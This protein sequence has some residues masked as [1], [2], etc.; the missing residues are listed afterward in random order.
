MLQHE[1]NSSDKNCNDKQSSVL[2]LTV[3]KKTTSPFPPQITPNNNKTISNP[4]RREKRIKSQV[5]PV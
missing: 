1:K 5:S 2:L 4:I 3:E